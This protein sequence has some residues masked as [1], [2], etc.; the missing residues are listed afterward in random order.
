MFIGIF[1]MLPR[2]TRML[3]Q[4]RAYHVADV[5][6][7]SRCHTDRDCLDSRSNLCVAPNAT[8]R[9]DGGRSFLQLKRRPG[10]HFVIVVA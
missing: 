6:R 9:W 4:D 7:Y 2:D 5:G 1:D 3:V 10:S 8:Q